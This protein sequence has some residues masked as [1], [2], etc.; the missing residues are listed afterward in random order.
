MLHDWPTNVRELSRLLAT[1][2]PTAGLKLSTV[3]AFLGNRS[4]VSAPV[5]TKEAVIAA[6]ETS[7][8]NQSEAAR[9]LKIDRAKLRREMKKHGLMD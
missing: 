9:K 3:A 7:K 1:V 6:L 2:D 8:R 5:L 4:P